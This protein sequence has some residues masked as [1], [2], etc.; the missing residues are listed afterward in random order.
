MIFPPLML[1]QLKNTEKKYYESA[2]GSAKTRNEPRSERAR[3]LEKPGQDS[4]PAEDF[5]MIQKNGFNGEMH[6]Y[7]ATRRLVVSDFINRCWLLAK[8]RFS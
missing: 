1:F 4:A 3:T 2:L 6:V 7:V 5:K 8:Y